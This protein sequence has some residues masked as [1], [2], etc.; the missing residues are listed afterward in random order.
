MRE[1]RLT[2]HLLQL[3]RF[4]LVN[5]F[6]V[7]EEDG[8]TLVDAGIGDSSGDILAAAERI[9]RPITHI[10]LTHAHDDHV[11]SVDAL[12]ER[13]P[14]VELAVHPREE[15]LRRGDKTN[16]PG[17]KSGKGLGNYTKAKSP[18]TRELVPGERIGSLEVVPSPGHTPG[19]VSFLDTRDRALIAGDAFKTIGGLA[20]G[21]KVHYAFPIM[22][23]ASWDRS[24]AHE[25]ARALVGLAPTLLAVGH[26]EALRDPRE[27]MARAVR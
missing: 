1:T 17:E 7:T 21:G 4:R 24:V 22:A 25:S 10:V 27:E 2:E 14:G 19:H 20:H 18:A 16:D 8:L 15:R 12:V 9:G 6:L 23:A 26:G 5:C 13:L 11:G 3:T